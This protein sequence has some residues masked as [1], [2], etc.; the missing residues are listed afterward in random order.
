V[1]EE[2]QMH[3]HGRHNGAH[4]THR[5]WRL[6]MLRENTCQAKAPFRP[7]TQHAWSPQFQMPKS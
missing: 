3:A 4:W 5:K 1:E 6:A 7:A 2:Q